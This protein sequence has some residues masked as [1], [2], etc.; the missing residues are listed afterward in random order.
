M[1]E[2]KKVKL[3]IATLKKINDL[4]KLIP[5]QEKK[6]IA[7]IHTRLKCI[8]GVSIESEKWVRAYQNLGYNVHLIAGRIGGRTSKPK[9]VIP[10]MD[11]T[12]SIIR[13]LKKLAFESKLEKAGKDSSKAL[14]QIIAKKIKKELLDYIKKNNLHFLSIENAF[15]IPLNIPLGIALYEI[16]KETKI[17]IIARHHDFYWER[18]YFCQNNNILKILKEVFP[19]K[20]KNIVHVTIS[21]IA[22]NSLMR[23][24]KIQATTIPNTINFKEVREID[25]YNKDFRESFGIK[26]D[27]L[28]FLQPTRIT[29]RKAIER[30]VEMVA[31]MNKLLKKDNVLM[32]TGPSLYGDAYYY[33]TVMKEARALGVSVILAS[34]RINLKRSSSKKKK[35]YSIEDA[36]VHADVITFPSEVEGFGNPILEAC[37]YKK[38]LFVNKFPVFNEIAKNG[39]DFVVMD[40]HLTTRIIHK[41]H[42]ILVD[43]KKREKMVDKN[44][45]LAKKY[46]SQERLERLLLKLLRKSMRDSKR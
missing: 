9:L 46:Y 33:E 4:K 43:S 30:S 2:K 28:I 3:D 21:S 36:Y 17:P 41:M 38:P 45:R 27:Q 14:N 31:H 7:M 37:A 34:D 26:K 16:S 42:Q 20:H 39:F 32:I 18:S 13:A 6:N 8:D 23:K 44:Y 29:K 1:R 25:D 5:K 35:I 10:E 40:K 12:N 22:K 19:P 15:S 11:F 24:K